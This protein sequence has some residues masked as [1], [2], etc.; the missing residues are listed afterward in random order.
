[1]AIS[2]GYPYWLQTLN[3]NLENQR[4]ISDDQYSLPDHAVLRCCRAGYV[5]NTLNGEKT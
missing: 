4:S 1:M 5:A 2:V 3:N